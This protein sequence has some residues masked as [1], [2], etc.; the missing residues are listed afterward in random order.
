MGRRRRETR[1]DLRQLE[2]QTD[3]RSARFSAW[4][5]REAAGILQPCMRQSAWSWRRSPRR[6]VEIR[7]FQGE[8]PERVRRTPG[9]GARDSGRRPCRGAG[10][11]RRRAA[12]P[13]DR[14]QGRRPC[15]QLGL[16]GDRRCCRVLPGHLARGQG[17][18][19]TAGGEAAARRERPGKRGRPREHD[20]P[21]SA[22]AGEGARHRS[23]PGLRPQ[24]RAD[25]HAQKAHDR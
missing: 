5:K 15:V 2:C 6:S 16:S 21:E 22:E 7:S 14:H 4:R 11:R 20:Q 8:V 10:P 12:G 9:R 13:Q 23:A 19:R 24:R 18:D 3:R 17:R 25:R 1:H